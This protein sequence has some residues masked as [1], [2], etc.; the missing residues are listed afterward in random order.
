MGEGTGPTLEGPPLQ[1]LRINGTESNV[2]TGGEAEAK[3]HH[4]ESPSFTR[5]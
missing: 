2:V 4:D 3:N 5:K 1:P